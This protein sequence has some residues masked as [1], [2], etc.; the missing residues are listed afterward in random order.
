[1]LDTS[2]EGL[3]KR[4]YRKYAGGAPIKE[5]L[6]AGIVDVARIREGDAVYDFCCG[7]GTM[8]IEAAL[9]ALNIAPGLYRSFRCETWK[10][11]DKSVFATARKEA[12]EAIKKDGDFEG[13]GFDIDPEMV[14]LTMQNAKAAGVEK[15]ITVTRCDIAQNKVK[16][17]GGIL[18]CNPPYGE[19]MLEKGEARQIYK[20]LGIIASRN[21]F[22][23]YIISSDESF[24]ECFGKGADR[25]RKLYNGELKC[26]LYMYYK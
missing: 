11:F 18:I 8:L 5:T 17:E 13:I 25:K 2:G 20:S 24:E 23:S 12:I 6:A 10:T 3:H 15:Y 22:K 7:S 16:D 9:K 26:Q 14:E 4:G 19:R 1:M 21:N